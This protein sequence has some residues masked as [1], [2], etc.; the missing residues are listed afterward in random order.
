M[1]KLALF[2]VLILAVTYVSAHDVTDSLQTV[3]L[4]PLDSLK[5]ELRNNPYDSL[6][7][8]LYTQI[9][10]Y[11]LDYDKI[12]NKKEKTNYQNEAINYTIMAMRNYSKYYD[13]VGMRNSFDNLV[14]VYRAQKKFSQAKWF[15]LQSNTLSRAIHDVPNIISSL[16]QLAA[17]KADIKDYSLAMRDLNEALKLSTDNRMPKTEVKVQEGYAQL[18]GKMKNRTKEAIA[19]K[20]RDFL[21][22]S[23]K[24]A[25]Q[26]QLAKLNKP[27]S[28]SK[29]KLLAIKK[30]KPAPSK[31]LASL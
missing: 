21:N 7:A 4:S 31:K 17:I 16:L 11:Y 27:D 23:I 22:D 30:T 3:P 20:R 28:V 10:A 29:K 6:K 9:A 18:Y 15:I 24:K 26:A 13:T 5:Q 25:E 1:K 8:G 2:L 12:T 14:K 19:L